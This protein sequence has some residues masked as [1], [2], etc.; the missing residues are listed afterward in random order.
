[1]NNYLFIDAVSYLTG[2]SKAR[3]KLA[4]NKNATREDKARVVESYDWW[5]MTEQDEKVW[6]VIFDHLDNA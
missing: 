2:F 6:G 5:R 3:A 1:M 4:R